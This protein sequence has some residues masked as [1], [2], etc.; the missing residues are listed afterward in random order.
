MKPLGRLVGGIAVCLLMSCGEKQANTIAE[1][2]DDT[3]QFEMHTDVR[4][5]STITENK[6]QEAAPLVSEPLQ[7][8]DAKLIFQVRLLETLTGAFVLADN[9]EQVRI[10]LC[11]EQYPIGDNVYENDGSAEYYELVLGNPVLS[12]CAVEI[13]FEHGRQRYVRFELPAFISLS[14]DDSV[15]ERY[16]MQLDALQ[17]TWPPLQRDAELSVE[18]TQDRLACQPT[19]SCDF[20]FTRVIN[21]IETSYTLPANVFGVDNAAGDLLRITLG[22]YRYDL[23]IA[24]NGFNR[25]SD[26]EFDQRASIEYH[27]LS[28]LE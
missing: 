23:D 10:E 12:E 22:Q 21:S 7:V 6:W 27:W 28:P 20:V 17:V 25:D 14:V 15:A 16:N 1:D 8:V 2:P 13:S 4:F 24:K 9:A 11:G 26:V 3:R 18:W 19:S 5:L